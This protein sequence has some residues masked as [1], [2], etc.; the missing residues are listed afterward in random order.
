VRG[1]PALGADLAGHGVLE[2]EELLDGGHLRRRRLGEAELVRQPAA[3]LRRVPRAFIRRGQAVRQERR[4][5]VV[6]PA[7]AHRV[8]RHVGGAPA[9]ASVGAARSDDILLAVHLRDLGHERPLPRR[10]VQL[11]PEPAA[12]AAAAAARE[13]VTGN[14]FLE[15]HAHAR[16]QHGPVPWTKESGKT[17]TEHAGGR[18]GGP[19]S[20]SVP[21]IEMFRGRRDSLPRQELQ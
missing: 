11:A 13:G 7:G 5:R 3:V 21:E 15:P 2:L 1:A 20:V 6:P 9:A 4:R 16:P 18:A 17:A 10:E 19:P 14:T 12:T 8:P